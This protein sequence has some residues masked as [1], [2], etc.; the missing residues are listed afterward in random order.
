MRKFLVLLFFLSFS[1]IAG[2]NRTRGLSVQLYH[3]LEVQSS[4]DHHSKMLK[5][6]IYQEYSRDKFP[7]GSEPL[8]KEYI[9]EINGL[10]HRTFSSPKFKEDVLAL[11]VDIFSEEEL[12]KLIEFYSTP[13]GQKIVKNQMQ[14]SS[15]LSF[16][17]LK[18][19]EKLKP[20]MKKKQNK[21]MLRLE[22]LP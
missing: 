18:Y 17:M 8:I 19:I 22:Q 6:K 13:I 11:Y 15:N 10:F 1:I 7:E 16:V 21:M 5:D 12:A 3:I 2:D 4:I 20:E 9:N 14:L